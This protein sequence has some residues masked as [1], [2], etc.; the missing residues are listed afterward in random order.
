M[1]FQTPAVPSISAAQTPWLQNVSGGGFSLTNAQ[2]GSFTASLFVGSTLSDQFGETPLGFA[3][4]T[5]SNLR[6]VWQKVL[7]ESSGSIGSNL[8]LIRYSDAGGLLGA[9]LY[10]TRSTGFIGVGPLS[11]SYQLDV[12]GDIH[13][14]GII[15]AQ[16]TAFG[17]PTLG[18]LTNVAALITNS[19]SATAY[20][21]T[22]G[23]DGS[24]A[25]WLQAM[26]IDATA[27]A[28]SLC[29]QPSGGNV[30]IN[31]TSPGYKLDVSGDCNLSSGSIYRINGVDIR[32][33]A[34]TPWLQNVNGGGFQLSGV[35]RIT[36]SA[37][38]NAGS[39]VCSDTT[40]SNYSQLISTALSFQITNKLRWNFIVLDAE[41]GS[42]SGSNLYLLGYD[43]AGT[44]LG[45][46]ITFTRSSGNVTLSN[47][48]K[49]NDSSLT[50]SAF[51]P[52]TVIGS[53]GVYS[54]TTATAGA[55]IG[56]SLYLSDNGFY[57]SGG[58]NLA[59]GLS[60]VYE[61]ASGVSSALA[62][63]TYASAGGRNERM[64]I[65]SNGF[66]GINKTNPGYTLDVNGTLAG[67]SILCGNPASNNVVLNGG[68][69][70]WF[71]GTN[72]RWLLY[73]QGTESGGNAG[74]D[75][76]FA[77]YSDAGAGLAS[78]MVLRRS[79]GYVGIGKFP[80][81][82]LDV[83]GDFQASGASI[84][85][86]GLPSSNPGAGSKKLWYDPADSNRVK[87]AV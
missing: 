12:L 41:A 77:S 16:A 9:V 13:C 62:F 53:I 51:A 74:S 76:Y 55:P 86:T 38:S 43:D 54:A 10:F 33:W 34:Q 66:V 32:G 8:Q 14:N 40:T 49:V 50:G 19:A 65:L 25:S 24:G 64:R 70:E 72:A 5:A 20:G 45:K 27:T 81:Y 48:L 80:S 63:Y 21:L 60:A 79:L 37:A 82:A 26:R 87:F 61:V 2:S 83:L 57:Y 44:Y 29:L 11:P 1:S 4:Y 35:N 69:V 56:A 78:V 68:G 58:Y 3:W 52:L 46:G 75:F 18:Q 36:V 30:G 39:Y 17:F 22:M 73:T 28:Y 67:T 59:P 47:S 31:N 71:V 7:A 15:R 6:W 23:V 42:N 84:L 85:L